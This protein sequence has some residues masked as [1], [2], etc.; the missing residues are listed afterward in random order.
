MCDNCS[1][2]KTFQQPQVQAGNALGHHVLFSVF[3]QVAAVDRMSTKTTIYPIEHFSAFVT[4]SSCNAKRV[5]HR[6]HSP[7]APLPEWGPTLGEFPLTDAVQLPAPIPFEKGKFVYY[8][9]K[10]DRDASEVD[11]NH[12]MRKFAQTSISTRQPGA[13][14][15]IELPVKPSP[16]PWRFG[17]SA[18]CPP[19]KLGDCVG[20]TFE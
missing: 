16:A 14:A 18:S 4:E 19:A 7:S 11:L 2:T 20:P 5:W 15:V 8:R 10:R 13:D 3:S 12:S 1:S 6:E 17:S 9:R